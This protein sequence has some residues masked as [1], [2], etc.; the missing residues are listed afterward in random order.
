M[1]PTIENHTLTIGDHSEPLPH[2]PQAARVHA[3][4][5]PSTLR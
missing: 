1:T 5:V 4:A 3:W 2:L